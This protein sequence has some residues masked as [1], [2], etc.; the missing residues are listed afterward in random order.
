M[1]TLTR[2]LDSYGF[3]RAQSFELPYR[4]D[5]HERGLQHCFVLA[6]GLALILSRARPMEIEERFS[7]SRELYLLLRSRLRKGRNF[8]PAPDLLN[9]VLHEIASVADP[10]TNASAHACFRAALRT[11]AAPAGAANLQPP[12][13]RSSIGGRST[14]P[15]CGAPSGGDETPT[16]ISLDGL[17][18]RPSTLR[19]TLAVKR[20]DPASR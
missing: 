3:P 8:V 6:G 1:Q 7:A 9:D 20:G 16:Q 12:A 17:E 18:Q 15:R 4:C 2:W 14:L 5:D 10:L 13:P 19:E 11:K